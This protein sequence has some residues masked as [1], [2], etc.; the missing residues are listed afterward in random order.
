MEKYIER[1]LLSIINQSFQDFAITIVD[2][3][4]TDKTGNIIKKLQINDERIKV[5]S[6]SKNLGLYHSRI[7]S[8]LNSNS[9]YII[10]MDPDDMYMNENLLKQLYN[11]NLK[12]NF[13]IIE[14]SVF[15]QNENS[16]KVCFP[17]NDFENHYQKFS[18]DII[19]QPELS[20]IIFYLPDTKIASKT[21]CRNVWNKL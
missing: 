6:H 13:D 14:F 9:K 21:I 3:K 19:Y 16:N 12:K 15:Q 20:G 4:S 17:D 2:D 11:S 5:I 7:E 1:N 8:I 10:I 18:K